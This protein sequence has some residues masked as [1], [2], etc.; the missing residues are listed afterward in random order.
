MEGLDF[1]ATWKLGFPI[2]R[3]CT[4]HTNAGWS[5]LERRSFLSFGCSNESMHFMYAHIVY[6]Y[7]YK[8]YVCVS[9]WFYNYVCVCI[10]ML[11]YIVLNTCHS[12]CILISM[13]KPESKLMYQCRTHR[14]AITV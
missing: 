13:S 9:V 6:E 14:F 10:C 7:E 4:K 2:Q 11:L 5:K 1:F 3:L 8:M 12:M